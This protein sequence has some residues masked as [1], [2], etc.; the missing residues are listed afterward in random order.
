MKTISNAGGKM[1]PG[2]RIPFAPRN[3][4]EIVRHFEDVE[5]I[6]GHRF[7]VRMRSEPVNL[8]HLWT[9]LAN[10][11]IS[12]S[13]NFAR[14]LASIAGRVE[15]DQVCCILA[16]QLHDEMGNGKF[17]RAHVNLFSSMMKKLQPWSP[18][19]V[20]DTVLGPGRKL[21]PRLAEIYGA[22]DVNAALGAVMAGE[23][24][25]KQMDQFIGDEFRRQ[26][27]IDIRSL[28]WLT[29]HE[30]LEVEHADSSLVLAGLLPNSA[31][32]AVWF[33][34]S[35]LRNAGWAFLDDLYDTCY[36]QT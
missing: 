1:R 17:E 13:K 28:E 12:I 8:R 2:E 11:Q 26:N 4:E 25:A 32:N 16:E 36:G 27:E 30:E 3:A 21:D 20:D 14:R 6:T 7:M 23:V 31:L 5:Q 18:P 15:S 19:V 33:G 22:A 34:A 24:F 35:E 10:F 9:L 29:L